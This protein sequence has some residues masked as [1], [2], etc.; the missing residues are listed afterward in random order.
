[1]NREAVDLRTG[2]E[3][4]FHAQES[5]PP[6]QGEISDVQRCGSRILT[7]EL[8]DSS[9]SRNASN[10]GMDVFF[11]TRWCVVIEYLAT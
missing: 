7:L 1:M 5:T 3:Q 4:T 10:A 11:P 9:A 8:E 6:H 2:H